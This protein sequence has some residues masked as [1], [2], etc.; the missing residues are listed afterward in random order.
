MRLVCTKAA[1]P[2]VIHKFWDVVIETG[3][4]ALPCVLGQGLFSLML[5]ATL[6]VTALFGEKRATVER[7]ALGFKLL[8]VALPLLTAEQVR[9]M[10]FV[11]GASGCQIAS[12]ST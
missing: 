12:P 9:H 5:L 8:R 4:R 11:D 1:D 3:L 2:A 6:V 7:K 10:S